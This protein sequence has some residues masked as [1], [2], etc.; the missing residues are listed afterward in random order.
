[1]NPFKSQVLIYSFVPI[2]SLFLIGKSEF[3]KEGVF[4]F[5]FNFSVSN[6]NEVTFSIT[7]G[8]P[9]AQSWD[10]GDGFS[11][12]APSPTHFYGQPGNYTVCLTAT[13]GTQTNTQCHVVTI[14]RTDC[15]TGPAT[16]TADLGSCC[17]SLAIDNPYQQF[18]TGVKVTLPSPHAFSGINFNISNW[19]LSGP[20]T[21]VVEFGYTGAPHIPL[22]NNLPVVDFCLNQPTAGPIPYTI[23]LMIG[24][25]VICSITDTLD[26]FLCI[27]NTGTVNTTLETKV[28]PSASYGFEERG[29][30]V[31]ADKNTDEIYAIGITEPLNELGNQNNLFFQ[32]LDNCGEQSGVPMMVTGSPLMASQLQYPII[33]AKFIDVRSQNLVLLGKS[34]AFVSVCTVQ[35]GAQTDYVLIPMELDGT[36]ISAIEQLTLT[37]EL[38]E[39][40]DI[41]RVGTNDWVIVGSC[42]TIGG[43]PATQK[44]FAS[45]ITLSPPFNSTGNDVIGK[46]YFN[47][48]VN[49][50]RTTGV[51][52]TFDPITNLLYFTGK[53]PNDPVSYTHLT[54]PT[55]CSV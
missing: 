43:G 50:D 35:K 22:Q 5:D 12:T 27:P 9:V 52:V 39:I 10:F 49:F 29:T 8:T 40:E 45:K 20:P 33:D 13:D 24:P 34:I 31:I 17:F 15:C 38:E 26:C 55:I 28:N 51:A 48:G 46:F 3:S 4:P 36:A 54:L 47:L 32:K 42:R 11:D 23:D 7:G 53:A 41:I 16:T 2:L 21:N 1:M 30:D 37:P 18:F 6:C 19:G 44:V 14:S 25:N